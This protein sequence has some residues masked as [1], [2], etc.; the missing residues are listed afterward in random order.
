MS[1]E[2]R[3]VAAKFLLSFYEYKYSLDII[4]TLYMNGTTNKEI[5]RYYLVVYYSL[6]EI[7]PSEQFSFLIDA[8]EYLS[9][10][11]WCKLFN[12]GMQLNFQI[13]DYE[14]VRDMCC[15]NCGCEE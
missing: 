2:D 5:I 7:N 8:Q 12:G 1:E 9:K 13:L 4:H 11:E 10:K 15:K 3:F 6:I 14:I